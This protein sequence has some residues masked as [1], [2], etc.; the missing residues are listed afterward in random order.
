MLYLVL[1]HDPDALKKATQEVWAAFAS[2]FEIVNG[3]VLN[4]CVPL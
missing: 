2:P 3:P 1:V 4:E